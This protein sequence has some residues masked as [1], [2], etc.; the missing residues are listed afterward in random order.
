MTPRTAPAWLQWSI[1]PAGFLGTGAFAIAWIESGRDSG[2][3]IFLGGLAS[4]VKFLPLAPMLEAM[5]GVSLDSRAF[6][7]F[8]RELAILAGWIAGTSLVAMRLFR[9]RQA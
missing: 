9:F 1:F 6:W 8:P 2:A 5:R 3:A 7:E 4:V